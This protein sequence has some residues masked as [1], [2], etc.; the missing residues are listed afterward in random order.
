MT[1]AVVREYL[2]ITLYDLLIDALAAEHSA[3]LVATEAAEQWLTE[4]SHR[5]RRQLVATRREAT[6]QEVLEIAT[7]ARARRIRAGGV[8]VP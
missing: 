7:G 3:R 6:T 2:Y 5:V 8:P 1:A 4:R